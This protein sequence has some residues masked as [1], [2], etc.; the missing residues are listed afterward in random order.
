M[1]ESVESRFVRS[2]RTWAF[3]HTVN[4]ILIL[5]IVLIIPDGI[6]QL[7]P[8]NGRWRLTADI[9]HNPVY[10]LYIIYDIV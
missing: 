6:I 8:F 2:N 1:A 9:I 7:F 3:T 4:K 10:S 5:E